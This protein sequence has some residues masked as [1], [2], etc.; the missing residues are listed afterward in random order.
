MLKRVIIHLGLYFFTLIVATSL[1]CGSKTTKDGTDNGN[2]NNNNQTEFDQLKEEFCAQYLYLNIHASFGCMFG[3]DGSYDLDT[4]KEIYS[5]ELNDC[6]G[7]LDSYSKDD[8]VEIDLD[9]L[10]GCM[11]AIKTVNDMSCYDLIY[12]E[13]QNLDENMFD[14]CSSFIKGHLNEGDPCRV[15]ECGDGMVCYYSGECPGTCRKAPFQEGEECRE[16]EECADGLYC[17]ID[18]NLCTAKKQDTQPCLEDRECLNGVCINGECRG[19]GA[20]GEQCDDDDHCESGLYCDYNSGTCKP[21]AKENE[22][23]N[24][25]I[26]DRGLLCDLDQFCVPLDGASCYDYCDGGFFFVGIYGCTEEGVCKR[27]GEMGDSCENHLECFGGYMCRD[28]VCSTGYGI[29]EPCDPAIKEG[30]CMMGL[31][32]ADSGVC[33]PTSEK[34]KSGVGGSC[35]S[36]ED[37]QEGLVCD[38]WQYYCVQPGSEGD[39]C[40]SNEECKEGLVCKYDDSGNSKCSQPSNQGD[41]CSYDDE[42]AA[43]LY[44]GPDNTC[45]QRKKEGDDCENDSECEQG[46]FCRMDSADS[47]SGVCSSPLPDRE[48][49]R[50]DSWCQSDSCEYGVCGGCYF[51]E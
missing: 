1:S 45:I 11:D 49:C 33:R 25:A 26:C 15:F 12:G 9:S 8:N 34:P 14:P 5:A 46:L 36:N 19:R 4:I 32:C 7:I 38:Q 3:L 17:D 47:T 6:I 18:T 16:D 31:Y 50:S 30:G 2:N 39:E 51:D 21:F 44:C 43:G 35:Y 42:C 29:D 24:E 22:S 40:F 48:G 20:E 13:G 23:C 27:L 37:C 28:G 41:S 10:K